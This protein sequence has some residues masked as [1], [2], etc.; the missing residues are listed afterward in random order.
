[1]LHT[2]FCWTLNVNEKRQQP[3]CIQCLIP[4]GEYLILN[5][6]AWRKKV[7]CLLFL[8]LYNSV[9]IRAFNIFFPLQNFVLF[10]RLNFLRFHLTGCRLPHCL[11]VVICLYNTQ[12]E[13][14]K[15]KVQK[16]MMFSVFLQ[17][18]K[19]KRDAAQEL[20][21]KEKN[22][23]EKMYFIYKDVNCITILHSNLPLRVQFKLG[24]PVRDIV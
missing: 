6:S 10:N 14:V 15:R 13:N 7:I 17:S 11:C 21:M 22:E 3:N 12:E 1:M 16:P 8:R 18:A 4:D 19:S 2:L 20:W 24:L 5:L 23:T 9:S